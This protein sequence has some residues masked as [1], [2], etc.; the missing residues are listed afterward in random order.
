M[1]PCSQNGD[2]ISYSSNTPQKQ[3]GT[4]ELLSHI[5]VCIYIYTYMYIEVQC[6]CLGL[7][8]FLSLLKALTEGSMS[9]YGVHSRA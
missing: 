3:M 1:V 8:A 7:E 6:T 9:V 5:H 4:Y 2:R